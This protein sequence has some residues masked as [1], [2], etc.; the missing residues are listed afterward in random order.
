MKNNIYNLTLTALM[1]AILCIV[2]PWIIPIGVIPIS[3]TNMAVYLTII[4]LDKKNA[5]I[6]VAL[7]LL[8]G[9]VGLPVFSGFSGG[10]GKVFGPTGGYLLGYLVLTKIAGSVLMI[11]EEKTKKKDEISG[12]GAE[13]KK[14]NVKDRVRRQIFA[15]V[16][17]TLGLYLFG[18]LWLMFQSKLGF[19]AAVSVGVI[20]FVVFDVMK[21]VVAVFL[22]NEVK[23]RMR[24]IV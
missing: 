15:L 24:D 12:E 17:G 21:I 20:P 8:I 11:C 13:N 1:A 6:S 23:K 3:L 19:L 18:T 22:G 2:G 9:F 7:Y 14:Q 5:M 16:L 10:A 4:L